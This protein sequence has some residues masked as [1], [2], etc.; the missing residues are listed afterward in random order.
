[1]G[2]RKFQRIL[3]RMGKAKGNTVSIEDGKQEVHE[4]I[5]DNAKNPGQAQDAY[6]AGKDTFN[7]APQRKSALNMLGI[8]RKSSPLD[9]WEDYERVPGTKEF[10]KGS[11]RK[12]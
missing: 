2:D 3:D 12:K 8:S 11:C 4:F 6:I 9:C 1:M 10:S 5:Q 7:K